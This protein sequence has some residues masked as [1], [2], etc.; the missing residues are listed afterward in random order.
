MNAL[1][2]IEE[3]RG[4]GAELLVKEGKLILRGI[5][6]PLPSELQQAVQ[7]QKAAIMEALGSSS[8]S[9]ALD[10]AEMIRSA[11]SPLRQ[12]R[13]QGD[14]VVEASIALL[15]LR[16]HLAPPLA[17][18]G[19]PELLALVR[20][21]VEYARER[22]HGPGHRYCPDCGLRLSVVAVSERCGFC[23]AKASQ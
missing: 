7:G 13:M 16:Q 1:E 6:P 23:N 22:T 10:Q 3:V 15:A 18:L 9:A 11:G 14:G 8:R 12:A 20:H 4:H 17:A 21:A 5:G 2:I 19:D